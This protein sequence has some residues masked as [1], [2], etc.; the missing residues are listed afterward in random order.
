MS[1]A[2]SLLTAIS[3]RKKRLAWVALAHAALSALFWAWAFAVALGFGF[4]DRDAWTAW[5]QVQVAVVPL[6]AFAITVPGRLLFP[7][8]H[9]GFGFVA[10]WLVNSALWAVLLVAAYELLRPRKEDIK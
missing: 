7:I 3:R 5:D 6:V 1:F 4:K 2:N 10:L 9:E 8:V